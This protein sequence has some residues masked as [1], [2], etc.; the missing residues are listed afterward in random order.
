MGLYE[1]LSDPETKPYFESLVVRYR[2][3]S[4]SPLLLYLTRTPPSPPVQISDVPYTRP[5]RSS[6]RPSAQHAVLTFR[7]TPSPSITLAFY[8][9]LMNLVDS[10][11]SPQPIGAFAPIR[12]E[13]TRKL[14]KT[15][16]E[17][18]E[19]IDR[20]VTKAKEPKKEEKSEI[21]KKK[22]EEKKK[23]LSAAELKKVGRPG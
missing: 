9:V 16:V 17:A 18:Y 14:R 21:V 8:R 4:R 3:L 13:I 5:I 2:C 20:E 19:T 10:L 6:D 22:K 12:A 23:G 11:T 7:L 1:L 15:R